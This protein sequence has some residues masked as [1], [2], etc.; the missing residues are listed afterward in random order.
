MVECVKGGVCSG[1]LARRESAEMRDENQANE[2]RRLDLAGASKVDRG[3]VLERCQLL[4][5]LV[6]TLTAAVNSTLDPRAESTR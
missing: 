4:L 6:N 3:C 5:C 2:Q 1:L